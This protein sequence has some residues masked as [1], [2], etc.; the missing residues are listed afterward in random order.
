MSSDV[1]RGGRR[2]FLALGVVV[3]L[4]CLLVVCLSRV[5][6]ARPRG[7]VRVNWSVPLQTIDGFGGAA[8]DFAAPLTE[9][10]AD[11]FFST[12]GL[13]ILRLQVIPDAS[14]CAAFCNSDF[15]SEGVTGCACVASSGP[16]LLTGELQ[17]VRQA[18]ARGVKTFIASSWSPPGYM[19]SNGDWRKGGSF[20]G[21]TSNYTSMA[22][23]LADYVALLSAND[24]PLYALGPQNEPDISTAYQSCKWTAQQFHD[25]IPYL[26]SAL[27]T[28]GY[29]STLV[30]FPENA[31][32]SS[33]F[34]DFAAAAMN[35]MSVAPDVGILAQHGYGG[36]RNIVAPMNYGSGQHIWITEDS[37]QS[38]SYDGSMKDALQ[39][40]VTIHR[41]L[42]TARVNAFVWWFL[43]DMLEQ[44]NG[45]DN[46]ALTDFK[47][48]IPKRAYITGNW[49]K[50][51]RPGW[52]SVQATSS[53]S[54]L[55]TAF[56]SSDGRQAAVV[57]VNRGSAVTGQVIEVGSEMGTAVTPWVTS[58]RQSL[59]PQPP[60]M[61]SAGQMVYTVPA[62][63]VVTFVGKTID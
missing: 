27:R 45:R 16:T 17:T 38:P 42:T 34:G 12:I 29:D 15:L 54:L 31:T 1:S 43:S 58:S 23:L 22:A 30:I 11:F 19:K 36:D 3:C 51:V 32:W 13:S 10:L 33:S 28:R 2:G 20:L 57:V 55:V 53:G 41:Y 46:A 25:F 39:W 4:L 9:G 5:W 6:S 61:I 7:P 18:Q 49:S 62:N 47:G 63:S 8:V 37:S 50:F 35:D 24:V 21:G 14:T 56:Q 44:G 59:S 26:R 60:V 40:A 48:N 52:H